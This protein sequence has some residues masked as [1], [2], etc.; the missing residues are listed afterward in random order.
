MGDVIRNGIRDVISSFNND[1]MSDRVADEIPL[2][3][4]AYD[5]KA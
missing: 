2:S 4:Q 1:A 3:Q 5:S